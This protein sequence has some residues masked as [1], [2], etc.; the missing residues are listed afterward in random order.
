MSQMTA[1]WPLAAATPWQHRPQFQGH[2]YSPSMAASPSG[3]RGQEASQLGVAAPA[4]SMALQP[5]AL[6]FFDRAC[7]WLI[8]NVYWRSTGHPDVEKHTP[9]YCYFKDKRLQARGL[10]Q[11]S[12]YSCSQYC[13]E[14][15]R[16]YGALAGIGRFL[17]FRNVY[18]HPNGQAILEKFPPW[19]EARALQP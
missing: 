17:V 13:A 12:P 7:L 1:F 5:R 8:E 19:L 14:A 16:K 11:R 10:P 15:I 6:N 4:H 3:W 2:G 18:C 9:F